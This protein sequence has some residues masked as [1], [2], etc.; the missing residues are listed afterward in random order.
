MNAPPDESDAK[1]V[2]PDDAPELDLE[3]FEGAH[4][5]DGDTLVKRGRGRPPLPNKRRVSSVPGRA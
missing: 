4:Q 3:W 5:Y 1:W 2:D